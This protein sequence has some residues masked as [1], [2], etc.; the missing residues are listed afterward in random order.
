[1]TTTLAKERGRKRQGERGVKKALFLRGRVRADELRIG[2][3][4]RHRFSLR[5]KG[6]FFSLKGGK[7]AHSN[8]LET[9]KDRGIIKGSPVVILPENLDGSPVERKSKIWKPLKWSPVLRIIG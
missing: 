9:R 4:D 7:E 5:G 1:M 2:E 3:N 6:D 8:N